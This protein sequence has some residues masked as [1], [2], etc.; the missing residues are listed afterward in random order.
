M[1]GVGWV[2][3]FGRCLWVRL[4]GYGKG[5][6]AQRGR[7]LVVPCALVR[8]RMDMALLSGRTLESGVGHC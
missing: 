3:G 7:S 4:V 2:V 6:T 5:R 8:M 1:Q